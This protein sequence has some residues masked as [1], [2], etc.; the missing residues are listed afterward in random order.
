MIGEPAGIGE[1]FVNGLLGFIFGYKLIGCSPFRMHLPDPQS[2]ILSS[3]GNFLTGMIVA[4]IFGGIK[5][6][7]KKTTT[8]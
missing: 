3:R 2:F 6:W 5:W 4:L 8:G 1:L 7:E